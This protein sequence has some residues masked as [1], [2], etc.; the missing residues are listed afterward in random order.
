MSAL[1]LVDGYNVIGAWQRL[2]R[3]RDRHG[4][5]AARTEL[6][7]LLSNY[8]AYQ[9]Y[10]TNLVFD[11]QYRATPG[12]QEQVTEQLVVSYTDPEQTADTYIEMTCANHRDELRASRRRV[13]VATSDRAQQLTVIGFGAEWMSTHRLAQ[14]VETSIQKVKQWQIEQRRKHQP[15]TLG[16]RLDDRIRRQLEH[17]R[18][19][20]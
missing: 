2:Q 5:E 16:S 13:I 20:P 1:L 11:A 4:L 15:K 19:Q 18:R 14:D 3:L 12:Q 10:A 7:E 8:S 9:G 17:W 6:I